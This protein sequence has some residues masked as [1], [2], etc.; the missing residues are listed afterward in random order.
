MSRAWVWSVP[1][2]PGLGN[3]SMPRG[4]KSMVRPSPHPW[5]SPLE[6]LVT[7]MDF[8][9]DSGND[10]LEEMAMGR[11]LRDRVCPWPSLPLHLAPRSWQL[12]STTPSCC[13]ASPQAQS[14]GA[15]GPCQ[16]KS[17]AQVVHVKCHGHHN[18]KLTHTGSL[19]G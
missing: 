17:P 15:G 9:G 10:R 4:G 2:A 5:A 7:R 3:S 12:C 13:S 11:G 6:G 18:K 1:R 19:A 14:N 8:L 16:N